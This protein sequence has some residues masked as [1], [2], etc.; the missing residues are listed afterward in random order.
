MQQ[1]IHDYDDNFKNNFHN[2]HDHHDRTKHDYGAEE[3]NYD[4]FKTAAI[5]DDRTEESDSGFGAVVANCWLDNDG[6]GKDFYEDQ[7]S[8]WGTC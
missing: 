5:I 3:I 7:C 4:Y 1:N 2:D 8:R 6:A